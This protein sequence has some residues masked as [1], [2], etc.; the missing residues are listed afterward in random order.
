MAFHVFPGGSFKFLC[1]H[2]TMT[3][4]FSMIFAHSFVELVSMEPSGSGDGVRAFNC[5]QPTFLSKDMA[6]NVFQVWNFGHMQHRTHTHSDCNRCCCYHSYVL[7]LK[8]LNYSFAC[9]S[10]GLCISI[11]CAQCALRRCAL[12]A[13]LARHVSRFVVWASFSLSCV[14]M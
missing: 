4:I 8:L 13:C 14:F 12:L 11:L 3:A 5:I 2:Y 7:K 10:V 6:V 9:H 1:A